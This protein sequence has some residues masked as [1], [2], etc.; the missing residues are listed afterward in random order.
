M[1]TGY[2]FCQQVGDF[3]GDGNL[4]LLTPLNLRRRNSLH[5]AEMVVSTSAST[6][7]R[8]G[9]GRS[10]HATTTRVSSGSVMPPSLCSWVRPV[11]QQT[12]AFSVSCW[13]GMELEFGPT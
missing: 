3:N 12:E 1:G 7:R 13:S 6:A 9:S 11:V 8:I 5:G 10:G 2:V 4:D